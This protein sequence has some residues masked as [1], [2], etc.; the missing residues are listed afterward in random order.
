MLGQVTPR[1]RSLTSQ[2][3][4]APRTPERGLS[5]A[6]GPS[7]GLSCRPAASFLAQCPGPRK[8]PPPSFVCIPGACVS[9]GSGRVYA[10]WPGAAL[11]A[12]PA[13][14]ASWAG[15]AVA[16]QGS[17]SRP[18]TH[19]SSQIPGNAFLLLLLLFSCLMRSSLQIPMATSGWG[20]RGRRRPNLFPRGAPR[21]PISLTHAHM[22]PPYCQPRPESPTHHGALVQEGQPQKCLLL[23][24]RNGLTKAQ[25]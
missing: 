7:A 15:A 23:L 12:G 3:S 1:V 16:T 22:L 14:Q 24:K 10:G 4:W 5:E 2:V 17:L 11:M 13:L 20:G 21:I 19:T 8:A 6:R 18:V 9:L 25:L